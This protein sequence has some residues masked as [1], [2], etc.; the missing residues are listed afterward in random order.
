MKNLNKKVADKLILVFYIGV[1]RFMSNQSRAMEYM[2]NVKNTFEHLKDES[3]ELIFIEQFETNESR[4]EAINPKLINE[5]DY[6]E[7]KKL[8]NE[9]KEKMKEFISH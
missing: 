5:E 6:E 3:T 9:Y 1:E 4:V 8:V 7:V 2:V